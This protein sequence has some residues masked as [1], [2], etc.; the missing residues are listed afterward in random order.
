MP[1]N[2]F[3][4]LVCDNIA[5]GLTYRGKDWTLGYQLSYFNKTKDVFIMNDILKKMLE[6]IY[7]EV[8][9]YGMGPKFNGFEIN[10]VDV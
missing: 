2:Y 8:S 6:E 1:F 5:A 7:T 4:E 3:L 10:K 9:K